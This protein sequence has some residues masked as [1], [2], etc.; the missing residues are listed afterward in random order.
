MKPGLAYIHQLKNIE[1]K[2]VTT[3]IYDTSFMVSDDVDV[4]LVSLQAAGDPLHLTTSGSKEDKLAPLKAKILTIQFNSTPSEDL[5]TFADGHDDRFKVVSQIENQTIFEGFLELNDNNEAFLPKT[6]IVTLSAN[7]KLAALKDITWTE[8]DGTF[9]VGRYKLGTI[10]GHCLKKT[11]LSLP[12]K[13]VNNLRHGTGQKQYQA[14]FSTSSNT[15]VVSTD[16]GFFYNGMEITTTGTASNNSTD[17]V[18]LV[19][20]GA[21]VKVLHLDRT[22]TISEAGVTTTFTDTSSQ[23]HFYDGIYLDAKTFEAE[24]GKSDDCYTVLEKILGEDCFLT[25]WQGA[26]WIMRVDEFDGNPPYVATFGEDGNFGQFDGATNFNKNVGFNEDIYL[27]DEQTQVTLQRE[28]G[29]VKET[30]RYETPQENPCNSDF[31]RGTGTEP[32]PTESGDLDYDPECWTLLREGDTGTN[33]SIDSAP[34]SGSVGII[35]KTYADG[36]ERERKLILMNAASGGR[37]YMKS[38]G[39]EVK[40]KSTLDISFDTRFDTN[41]SISNV[42][43]ALIRLEGDD[44]TMWDWQ[45]N[46][47]DGTNL[48]VEVFSGTGSFAHTWQYNRVADDTTE[49][50]GIGT[51]SREIPVDGTVYIRLVMGSVQPNEIWFNNLRVT[52][53]AFING[54]RQKYSG[55]Y[56]RVDRTDTQNSGIITTKKYLAARDEQVYISDS[57]EKLFKGAMMFFNGTRYIL[58]VKYFTSHAFGQSFPPG[59]EY[60]VPYGQTQAFAVWNQYRNANRIFQYKFQGRNEGFGELPPDLLNKYFITDNDQHSN[61]RHF[62]LLTFDHDLFLCESTGT[63]AETYRTDVPKMYG[64]VFSFKYISENT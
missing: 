63:M 23:K 24:I 16:D 2:I 10:I 25:Q 20:D 49:W 33:A 8:D 4:I 58:A 59:P 60:C 22:I 44:G 46:E 41:L 47:A 52:Y 28:H 62:I 18:N 14:L 38:A 31:S 27:S 9:P 1:E 39:I 56:S 30:Y 36:Y 29:F 26:W 34:V 50:R 37:H 45:Y 19:E 48:W 15:V 64:D 11:G 53:N 51:E 43:P 54:S 55:Q 42:F 13:V 61:N 57:P 3:T 35:R 40:A 17:V 6:N 12:I 21:G 5:S 7:D 32:T